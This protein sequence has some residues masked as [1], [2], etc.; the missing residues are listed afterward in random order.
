MPR[1][2]LNLLALALTGILYGL[3]PAGSAVAVSQAAS[4]EIDDF[5]YLDTSGEPHASAHEIKLQGL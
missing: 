4:L 3:L 5:S 1:S 2:S